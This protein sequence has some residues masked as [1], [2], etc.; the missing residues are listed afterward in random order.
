MP[1]SVI[2]IGQRAFL[3][4]EN[5]TTVNYKGSEEQW[6]IIS[7]ANDGNE[8]LKNMTINYNYTGK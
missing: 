4:C 6:N 1:D 5:L 3:D 7:F 2:T 8:A